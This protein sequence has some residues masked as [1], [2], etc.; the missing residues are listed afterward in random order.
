LLLKVERIGWLTIPLR[1][2]SSQLS[3]QLTI[4][5]VVRDPGNGGHPLDGSRLQLEEAQYS[6]MVQEQDFVL[7]FYAHL[8]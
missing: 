4:V 2:V 7:V 3:L 5:S 6:P 1:N 8:G